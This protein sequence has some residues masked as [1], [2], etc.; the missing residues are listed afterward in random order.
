MLTAITIL[1]VALIAASASEAPKAPFTI[2]SGPNQKHDILLPAAAASDGQDIG[3]Y[4]GGAGCD[5]IQSELKLQLEAGGATFNLAKRHS[6]CLE[7]TQFFTDGASTRR[8]G[9][10]MDESTVYAGMAGGAK[11][12]LTLICMKGSWTA[13]GLLLETNGEAGQVV[14][15]SLKIDDSGA[16]HV[17]SEDEAP[18]L[19]TTCGA[20]LPDP[21][22]VRRLGEGVRAANVHYHALAGRSLR[23][24]KFADCYPGDEAMSTLSV[25]FTIGD[26]MFEGML[27]SNENTARQ[28]VNA[29]I[30]KINKM[31]EGNFNIRIVLGHL[32]VKPSFNAV[33]A[34]KSS[35]Q[36][37]KLSKWTKPSEQALWHHIDDCFWSDGSVAG[38]AYVGTLCG[39]WATGISWDSGWLGSLWKTVAHEIG[40]NFGGAH[41]FEQGQ[42]ITGGIMDYGNGYSS[43]GAPSIFQGEVQFNV[44]HRHKDICPKLKTTL[45]KC[46]RLGSGDVYLPLD[47]RV[48][49]RH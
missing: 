45:P 7:G 25:G 33:C 20:V 4:N 12:V 5:P 27:D 1:A 15:Y 11:L 41:S 47:E 36:L 19:N 13:N 2:F 46:R 32:V 48:M 22:G 18:A 49:P 17:I 10:S 9:C 35:G 26:K 44:K 21:D 37:D 14:T 31:F 28:Y 24:T 43:Q 29:L 30:A 39:T 16:A 38:L 3:G 8:V 23:Y 6:P 40:H 42:L 34:D